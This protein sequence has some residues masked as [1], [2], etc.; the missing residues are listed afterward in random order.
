MSVFWDT[1][2]IKYRTECSWTLY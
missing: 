2:Y 1:V